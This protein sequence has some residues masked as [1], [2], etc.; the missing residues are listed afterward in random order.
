VLQKGLTAVQ[1][2]SEGRA[3]SKQCS[4]AAGDRRRKG[5]LKK[6]ELKAAD[7][8]GDPQRTSRLAPQRVALFQAGVW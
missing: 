6:R 5:E 8:C 2:R 3:S 1:V 4:L 7:V